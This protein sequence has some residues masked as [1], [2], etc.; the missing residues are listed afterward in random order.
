MVAD[1]RPNSVARLEPIPADQWDESAIAAVREAFSEDAVRAFRTKGPAPNVLATMLH[2]PALAGSFNRFGNVLLQEPAL[3]H[4]ARELMLL[5]VA[6]RTRARYEWVHHV[7]LAAHY[8]LG[9][10]DVAAVAEGTSESWTPLERDLVAAADQLLDCYRIDDETWGRLREQLDERQLVE[11]PFVVG[12][13]T[14][15]AMAFN[16]WQLQVE[17][18]IDTTNIPPLPDISATS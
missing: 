14:C 7:R 9:A 18:G 2:H 6:W 10:A 1:D 11:L 4:R 15:L 16:S 5:R 13:Y 12:A 8:G 17:D 3:G